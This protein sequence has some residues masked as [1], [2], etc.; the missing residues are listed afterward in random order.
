[1]TLCYEKCG[2][3]NN[4]DLLPRTNFSNTV[5][6]LFSYW[7]HLNHFDVSYFLSFSYKVVNFSRSSNHLLFLCYLVA[8]GHDSLGW[9]KIFLVTFLVFLSWPPQIL[10]NIMNVDAFFLFTVYSHSSYLNHF[11]YELNYLGTNLLL[12]E[13][14]R[15]INILFLL[16]WHLWEG[17]WLYYTLKLQLI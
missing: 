15:E 6:S 7:K 1:M 14:N 17:F 4:Y 12:N 3:C 2:H 8:F 13:K 5:F 11:F 9:C 16:Y 10:M